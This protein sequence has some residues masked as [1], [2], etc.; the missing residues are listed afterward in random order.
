MVPHQENAGR[1]TGELTLNLGRPV[2]NQPQM[3]TQNSIMQ[4]TLPSRA[5]ARATMSPFDIRLD[6]TLPC[7]VAV[8]AGDI[9]DQKY[10]DRCSPPGRNTGR[11][12]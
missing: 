8:M 11:C 10:A 9:H 6:P 5:G 1:F 7:A 4:N 2:H 12:N 3:M